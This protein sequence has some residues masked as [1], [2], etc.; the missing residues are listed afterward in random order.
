MHV[1]KMEIT[2]LEVR[3]LEKAVKLFSD[4]LGTTFHIFGEISSDSP[5][6]NPF[7]FVKTATEHADKTYQQKT[8]KIRLAIDRRGFVELQETIPPS[9]E[10]GLH[11]IHFKVPNLDEAIEEMKLKGIRLLAKVRAGSVKEA[12][13]SP[14]DLHG[15]RL[16][17]VEYDEP[18]LVDALLAKPE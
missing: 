18:T 6:T 5:S 11:G 15:I 13:F 8:N 10:E 4:I 12:I 2:I 17:L 7:P 9:G 14:E 1:E 16:C 3:N